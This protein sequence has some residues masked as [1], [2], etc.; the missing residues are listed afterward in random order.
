MKPTDIL[1]PVAALAAALGLFGVFVAFAGANP[2][3]VWA[4]LFSGA[5]GSWFS[6]QNTLQRAAPLMLT[7]LCTALP[8]QLGLLVIGGEGALVVGGVSAAVMGLAMPNASPYV[9][10]TSMLFAGAISGG[11]WI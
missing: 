4:T 11:L 2:V 3:E 6:F 7:A 8:M 10:L 5:F 9:V 1:L